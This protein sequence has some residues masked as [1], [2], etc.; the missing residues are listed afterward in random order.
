MPPPVLRRV[1][2]FSAML[3]L[4]GAVLWLVLRPA[5]RN[6]VDVQPVALSVSLLE[7]KAPLSSEV[8][9]DL[10]PQFLPVKVRI[11]EVSVAE[12]MDV[13]DLG[14]SAV[15]PIVAAAPGAQSSFNGENRELPLKAPDFEADYLSNPAPLYPPL[16]RQLREQGTTSLRVYVGADG[17]PLVV[18]VDRSSGYERLDRAAASTVRQWRFEPARQ[19][20]AAVAAWVVVPIRFSLR[21]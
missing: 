2:V 17:R 21:R 18:E 1:G 13:M 19:G 14:Q 4:H 6:A 12:P 5:I 9:P 11:P 3:A 15:T 16:S 20:D 8:E 10:A 7:A